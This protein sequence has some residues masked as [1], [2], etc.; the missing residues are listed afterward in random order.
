MGFPLDYE[1]A[2]LCKGQQSGDAYL[3]LHHNLIGN[4]GGHRLD[5]QGAFPSTGTDNG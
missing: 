2:C 5:P 4:S 1:V 3:D